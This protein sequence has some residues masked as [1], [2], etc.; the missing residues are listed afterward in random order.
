M[1]WVAAGTNGDTD[2]TSPSFWVNA[3]AVGVFLGLFLADKIHSQGSLRRVQDANEVAL[4]ELTRLHEAALIVQRNAHQDAMQR[5]DDHVRQLLIERDKAN[6]E[7]NEAVAV[8]RDFTLMAGAVL[9]QKPPWPPAGE[10]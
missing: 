7:R 2:F 3:G 5:A 6:A 9:G 10:K 4:R 1:Q 8:M